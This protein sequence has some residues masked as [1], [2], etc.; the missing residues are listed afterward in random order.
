MGHW[1]GGGSTTGGSRACALA[2]RRAIFVDLAAEVLLEEI[3]ELLGKGLWW[4]N[5]M[6]RALSGEATVVSGK[7]PGCGDGM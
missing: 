7:L 1:S 4:K 2:E 3:G 6:L 5:F